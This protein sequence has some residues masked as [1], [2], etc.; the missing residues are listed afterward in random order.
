MTCQNNGIEKV[1]E[2]E[3]GR[4]LKVRA[5]EH[6]R[7]I[8]AKKDSSG[9]YR[10]VRDDH[11]GVIPEIRFQVRKQFVDPALRQIEEGARIEESNWDSLL[12]TKQEWVPPTLGRMVLN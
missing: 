12:N 1:Y 9:L 10:H 4:A 11:Q 7:D 5:Q 8:K 3:S 6:L 2:G